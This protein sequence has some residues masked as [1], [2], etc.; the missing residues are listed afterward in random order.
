MRRLLPICT[1]PVGIHP[2]PTMWEDDGAAEHWFQRT[3]ARHYGDEPED[4]DQEGVPPGHDLYVPPRPCGKCGLEPS[5]HIGW[6]QGH[7]WIRRMSYQ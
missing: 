7:L 1:R 5:A 2:W 6:E 4:Q 3:L